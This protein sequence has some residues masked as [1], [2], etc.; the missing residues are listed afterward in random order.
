MKTFL[1]LLLIL[2]ATAAPSAP[3]AV[4]SGEHEGFTRLVFDYGQPVDWRFGRT[5]DGYEL[6]VAGTAP[7]YDLTG[8][9]RLIGT[10]RLAAIWADPASGNLRVGIACACHAIPF[11]FRPGIIVVDLRDGPPPKGSSFETALAG[12]ELPR[13]ADKAAPRPRARP[14]SA[15]GSYDWL[16]IAQED[17]PA[18]QGPPATPGTVSATRLDPL[19][20]L[21]LEQISRGAAQGVVDMTRP[22]KAH[23]PAPRPPFASANVRIGDGPPLQSDPPGSPTGELGAT[24]EP[25]ISADRLDV[26]AWTPE[27]P[28][29]TTWAPAMTGLVGEFDRPDPAAQSRAVRYLIGLGFGAEARQ[30]LDAFGPDLPDAALWRVM[31][32]IVDDDPTGAGPLHD[33]MACDSPAALWSM[34]AARTPGPGTLV[35]APAVRLAFSALP[36]HLRQ[37]LGPRLAEGFLTMGDTESARAIRDAILRAAPEAEGGVARMEATLDAQSGDPEQAERRLR[38]AIA[39]GGPEALPALADLVEL[40]ARRGLPVSPDDVPALEAAL[41]ERAGSRDEAR[42]AGA[43]ILAYAAAGEPGRAFVLLPKAPG[44]E[45]E[46]WSLLARLGSDD[47]ILRLGLPPPARAKATAAARQDMARRLLDLGLARPAR[48]WLEGVAEPDA[49][50]MARSDLASGAPREALRRIAGADTEEGIALRAEALRRLGD[51]GALAALERSQDKAEAAARS[52]ARAADWTGLAQSPPSPW[53]IL[54]GTVTGARQEATGEAPA[55]E[56]VLAAAHRLIDDSAL[57]RGQI[58]GLLAAL[59]SS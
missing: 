6:A 50:L 12:T 29:A 45:P 55:Q 3:V 2:I 39:R 37:L 40:R 11:E 26:A 4:T 53:Q 49:L 8:V 7:G 10:S 51:D 13:L 54:A 21:L 56:G 15:A 24:G 19:R 5:D 18:P 41:A 14:A 44:L 33:Q 47:Q 42:F 48:Q 23:S 20:A 16:Q 1:A 57:T 17:R 46:V 38:A 30:M 25:C 35:N 58:A 27:D 59:P 9:F 43:L 36:L 28:V 22:G 32:H 31:A 52:L 34:L